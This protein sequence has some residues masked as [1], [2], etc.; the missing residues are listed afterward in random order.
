MLCVAAKDLP[1]CKDGARGL[2]S[3]RLKPMRLFVPLDIH[4]SVY[5]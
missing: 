1:A 3:L 4:V 5:E 2:K